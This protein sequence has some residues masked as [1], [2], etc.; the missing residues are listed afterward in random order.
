M[1]AVSAIVAHG[2]WT[3]RKSY[4]S[5]TV[6]LSSAILPLLCLLGNLLEKMFPSEILELYPYEIEFRLCLT[7]SSLRLYVDKLFDKV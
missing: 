1:M 5:A 3:E 6:Y 4:S 7:S 2:G